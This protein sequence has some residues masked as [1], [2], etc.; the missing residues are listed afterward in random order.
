MTSINEIEKR[1]F[2]K[3]L[4]DINSSIQIVKHKKEKQEKEK[5][6]EIEFKWERKKLIKIMK[7]ELLKHLEIDLRYQTLKKNWFIQITIV[8]IVK[9]LHKYLSQ[10]IFQIKSWNNSV[11]LT[12][13]SFSSWRK[14]INNRGANLQYRIMLDSCVS[15]NMY[16]T[17]ISHKNKIQMRQVVLQML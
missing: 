14:I 4:L 16:T 11:C 17:L 7:N 12:L 3:S 9:I 13:F 15:L 6:K 2:L 8:L 5:I 10:K 1:P